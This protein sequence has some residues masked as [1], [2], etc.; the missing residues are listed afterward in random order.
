MCSVH[1]LPC[2]DQRSGPDYWNHS[3]LTWSL[4]NKDQWHHEA[5]LRGIILM[6]MILDISCCLYFKITSFFKLVLHFHASTDSSTG[7]CVSVSSGSPV[8]GEWFNTDCFAFLPYVCEKLRYGF[9][10]VKAPPPV[11]TTPPNNVGCAAGWIGFG[12][13]CFQVSCQIDCDVT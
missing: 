4:L 13:N 2:T 1:W 7:N 9:T 5:D 11:P 10:T 3:I 12:A 6:I 8:A